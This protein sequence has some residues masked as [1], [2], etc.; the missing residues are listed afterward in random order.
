MCAEY[1]IQH[2]NVTI[3]K[4]EA[5]KEL[6]QLR[7]MQASELSSAVAQRNVTPIR[8]PVTGMNGLIVRGE[9]MTADKIMLKMDMATKYQETLHSI[10]KI[11][12]KLSEDNSALRRA[13]DAAQ[14]E[15]RRLEQVLGRFEKTRRHDTF[16]AEAHKA[17]LELNHQLADQIERLERENHVLTEENEVLLRSQQRIEAVHSRHEEVRIGLFSILNPSHSAHTGR[18]RRVHRLLHH[19]RRTCTLRVSMQSTDLRGALSSPGPDERHRRR[20]CIRGAHAPVSSVHALSSS[21]EG[22]QDRARASLRTQGH[23]QD[24]QE[25]KAQGIARRRK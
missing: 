24:S 4:L 3:Q 21:G 5:E 25:E 16:T 10:E 18:R 2:R 20:R 11:N 23:G 9:M 6:Q 22:G 14:A 12:A 19:G 13:N 7:R 15:I 8:D 17:T 1:R